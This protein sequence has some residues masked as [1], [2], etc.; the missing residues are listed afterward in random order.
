MLQSKVYW[1]IANQVEQVYLQTKVHWNIMN[2][3][4][5]LLLRLNQN[6]L[7][8]DLKVFLYFLNQTSD[9]HLFSKWKTK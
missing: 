3:V 9:K 4:E 2:Q 1:N 7:N 5:Q 8:Q 6:I